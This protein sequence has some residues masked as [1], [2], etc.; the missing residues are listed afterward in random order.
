MSPGP[1]RHFDALL[2]ECMDVLGRIEARVAGRFGDPTGTVEPGD[3]GDAARLLRYLR[4]AAGV[5]RA[6]ESAAPSRM[7]RRDP[8]GRSVLAVVASDAC[9]VCGSAEVGTVESVPGVALGRISDARIEWTGQTEIDW[10]GS[11]TLVTDQGTALA[12][13]S[14]GERWI[15]PTLV[16]T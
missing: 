9:P 13:A 5:A 6:D 2:D 16:A 1:A 15:H 14:C 12:C 8:P 11:E 10:N 3:V 7:A 4:E